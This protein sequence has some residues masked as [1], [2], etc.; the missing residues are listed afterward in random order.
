MSRQTPLHVASQRGLTEAARLLIR[1]GTD[2]NLRDEN[3]YTA[4]HLASY[5]GKETVVA[6]LLGEGAD[7]FDAGPEDSDGYVQKGRVWETGELNQKK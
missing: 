5:Y 6:M 2:V 3:G 1:K 4:L 7:A